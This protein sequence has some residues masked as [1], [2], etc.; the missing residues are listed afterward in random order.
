MFPN[1][2]GLTSDDVRRSTALGRGQPMVRSIR[3]P[4]SA[5]CARE[6]DHEPAETVCL[7]QGL[8]EEFALD[9]SRIATLTSR[10]VLLSRVRQAVDWCVT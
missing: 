3:I 4:H 7:L 9:S 8:E 10:D 5:Y 6:R 2:S 1:I